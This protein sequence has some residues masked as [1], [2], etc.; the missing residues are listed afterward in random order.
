MLD[1]ATS[2]LDNQSEA[3]VQQAIDSLMKNRTVVVIAHRL[4]TVMNAD[5]IVVMAQGSIVEQGSHTTLLAAGGA[6]ATLYNAQFKEPIPP[7]VGNNT[8]TATLLAP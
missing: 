2:A 7:V 8:F 4:S 5:N 3:V 6:Y 1:E